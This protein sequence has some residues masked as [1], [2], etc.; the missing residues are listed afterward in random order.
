M[1]VVAWPPPPKIEAS[2]A[3]STSTTKPIGPC[4]KTSADPKPVL[5]PTSTRVKI[6]Y[7]EMAPPI[8][9]KTGLLSSEDSHAEQEL[10]SKR[11]QGPDVRT[12]SKE[13][14][15]GEDVSTSS[16]ATTEDEIEPGQNF[17][18]SKRSP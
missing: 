17:S 16:N 11:A 8:R 2:K 10:P 9:D 5:A 18:Y 15:L 7:D 14:T 3:V 4:Q 1:A 6:T 13:D 12:S